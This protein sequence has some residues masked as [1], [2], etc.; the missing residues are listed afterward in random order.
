[1]NLPLFIALRFFRDGRP[2]EKRKKASRPAV[3]IATLGVALGVAVMI[4][5]VCVVQ[6]FKQEVGRKVAGFGSH[7][8]VL[9]KESL[10]TPDGQSVEADAA[11]LEEI[12]KA[13]SVTHVARVSEKM[14]LIK[15]HDAFQGI[16]LKGL[17][18]EYD[19]TFVGES[20]V[21]GRLPRLSDGAGAGEVAISQ[22]Q[23]TTL[24]LKTGDRVYA[25]FFEDAIKTRRLKV[26]G[27][28][29]T[30]LK[31]FDN[32]YVLTD[33]A[34]VNRLNGWDGNECG[35]LEITVAGW[36]KLTDAT[37]QVMACLRK[38]H[39]GADGSIPETV[40]TVKERYPQVFSWLELLDFN[41]WVIL[42]LMVCVA[43]FTMVSGLFILILERTGAIGTL[44]ALGASNARIR[45]TFLYFA[46][47]IIG[48]GL[49]LGDVLGVGIVWLQ[50]EWGFIRL[51][52]TNYYMETVPVEI[53]PLVV[54]GLNVGTLLVTVL[55]LVGPSFL[56]SRIQPAKA[57]R[58]D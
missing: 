27:I 30:N 32:T 21:E 10:Y 31:I 49:L 51:D 44:K 57:I 34:T 28:Y 48:R 9:A 38:A 12:G 16:R 19:T 23:A 5:S 7:V 53:D 41:V 15:T 40:L 45:H 33:M 18:P 42:V 50:H 39:G 56:I 25:Y 58:F 37:W 52:A 2:E 3:Q 47:F 6:G 17:A 26:V 36:E 11:L 13:E 14:G 22:T 24:G 55:A 46:A 35:Q 29:Q 4:V 20:L 8:N 54:I 43:G 1:M